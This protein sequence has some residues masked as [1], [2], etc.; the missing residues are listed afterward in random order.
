[1][2]DRFSGRFVSLGVCAVAVTRILFRSHL[3]YDLDSVNFALGIQRFDPG[4]HQPHPPGYFL[5]VCLARLLNRFLTDPN[6]ALVTI[7]IAASCGAALAIYLLTKEWFDSGAARVSM[8]L[9]LVSPLCWFHGIVALTYIVECFF[10]ALIG[11]WCW[12]TYKGQAMFAVP[13][14]VAF[15]LAAGFRPSA[16]VLLAPLWLLSIRRIRGK[17]RWLA[18]LAA[19]VVVLAWLIPMMAAAGGVRQYSEALAHLWSMVP[20]KRTTLSSPWLAVARVATIGWIFVL[21]FGFA[22]L[23][24]LRPQPGIGSKR[25]TEPDSSE[26]GSLPVYSSSDS[27]TSSS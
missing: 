3:L 7:S 23:F 6:T 5:Y 26:S 11:Y 24:V 22:S 20:G 10:S 9:F 18:I 1:M 2:R 12:R 14:S 16:A 13:A 17:Q 25:R 8:V 19:G 21:C 4:A 15:A 27:S